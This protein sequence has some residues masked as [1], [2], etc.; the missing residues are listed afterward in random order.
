MQITFHCQALNGK[1]RR[2]STNREREILDDID[3]IVGLNPQTVGCGQILN[4]NAASYCDTE[5]RFSQRSSFLCYSDS[6]LVSNDNDFAKEAY[7]WCLWFRFTHRHCL[8]SPG[9]SKYLSVI[10]IDP[11]GCLVCLSTFRFTFHWLLMRQPQAD[12]VLDLGTQ[13]SFVSLALES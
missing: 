2:I 1:I 4:N 3:Q 10:V 13:T 12:A 8:R 9:A 7:R 11:R 6:W 5:S